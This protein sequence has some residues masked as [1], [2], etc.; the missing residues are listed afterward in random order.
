MTLGR[1]GMKQPSL[2]GMADAMDATV[3]RQALH[4]RF[5]YAAAAF[6][7]GCFGRVLHRLSV[8][9]AV[10]TPLLRFF[11]R[12][13]ILDS[14]SWDVAPALRHVLP[15]SGGSAS[16]AN[17]KVQVCLDYLTGLLR[18]VHSSPGARPDNA[19]SDPVLEMLQPQ[20]LV[21]FDL[22]YFRLE[23]LRRIVDTG[24]FF[25]SRL[26]AAV[27]VYEA[28]TG[29]PIDL[30]AML[31]ATS[32]NRCCRQVILGPLAGVRVTC[33]LIC[34]RVAPHIAQ[35]RRMAIRRSAVKKGHT[36]SQRHLMLADWTLLITNVPE[37]RWPVEALCSLYSLRWQIELLFKRLK[38]TLAIHD[39]NTANIDRL[40]CQLYGTLIIA[41][42]MQHLYATLNNDLWN[43]RKEQL[44]PDKLFKRLQER[45]FTL[46]QMFRSSPS[47][48]LRHLR[49]SVRIILPNCI[50]SRQ[51]SRLSS[52]EAIHELST[53]N[54]LQG[55]ATLT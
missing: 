43:A 22:G 35:R 40:H 29:T 28:S 38:S 32:A 39:T 30:C 54:R 23:T 31:R 25:L 5:T 24:A 13:L 3:S 36:C 1:A 15:G 53:T 52:L 47:A 45:A 2:G 26:F 19:S 18:L 12:V 17:C 27:T 44:S 42:L 51:P 46:A 16:S 21:L 7:Q 34:L 55:Q 4:Q 49:E 14:S 20:D 50:K 48:A 41:A 9:S 11:R 8:D 10:C 33:R 6:M 37:S